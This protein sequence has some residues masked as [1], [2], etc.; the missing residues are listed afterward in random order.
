MV[1][2]LEAVNSLSGRRCGWDFES[3]AVVNLAEVSHTIVSHIS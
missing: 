1:E 3:V 2:V